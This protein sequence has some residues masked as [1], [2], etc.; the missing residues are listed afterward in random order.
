MDENL[1]TNEE[2]KDRQRGSVR[3]LADYKLFLDTLIFAAEL[4]AGIFTGALSLVSLAIIGGIS[5]A[6]SLI[7]LFDLN[8]STLPPPGKAY[9]GFNKL[10]AIYGIAAGIIF[11]PAGILMFRLAGHRLD[12]AL[13]AGQYFPAIAVLAVC[14][15]AAFFISAWKPLKS[16]N[17][18]GRHYSRMEITLSLAVLAELLIAQFGRFQSLDPVISIFVTLFALGKAVQL[19][20]E[21][22]K[23]LLD[24]RLPHYEEEWIKGLIRLYAG[25]HLSLHDLQARKRGGSRWIDFHLAV[26]DN[27]PLEEAFDLANAL[28]KELIKKIP[29][30]VVIIH[31]EASLPPFGQ[32]G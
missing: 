2:V 3:N 21:S 20:L 4:A 14:L 5:L 30:A 9:F 11:I 25:A 1:R 8:Q 23:G 28:E 22:L 27:I 32:T 18:T 6:K 24:N 7:R 13:P 17:G 26:S 15:A 29:G 31:V 16:L 19:I 10:P 12:E